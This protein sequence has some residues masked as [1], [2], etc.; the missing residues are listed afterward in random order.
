MVDAIVHLPVF[1]GRNGLEVGEPMVR[2][3]ILAKRRARSAR[4]HA[5]E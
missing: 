3:G 5:V 1:L 2:S 4:R